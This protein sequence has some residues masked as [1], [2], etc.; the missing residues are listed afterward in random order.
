MCNQGHSKKFITY[1]VPYLPVTPTF[2][3]L[4]VIFAEVAVMNWFVKI[5]KLQSRLNFEGIFLVG[6]YF[7][8]CAAL[9]CDCRLRQHDSE[10]SHVC[11]ALLAVFSSGFGATG[12]S[13]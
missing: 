1:L 4:L 8:E 2:F 11:D 10:D 9:D 5:K 7:S 12:F 6:V 3:V 13:Q